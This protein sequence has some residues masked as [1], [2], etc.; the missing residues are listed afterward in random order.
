MFSY[1]DAYLIVYSPKIYDSYFHTAI[2]HL[3][4]EHRDKANRNKN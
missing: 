4:L 3:S 1:K 2:L